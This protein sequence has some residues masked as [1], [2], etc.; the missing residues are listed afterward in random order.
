MPPKQKLGKT[1]ITK[2]PKL[3]TKQAQSSKSNKTII[4][5]EIPDIIG[6]GNYSS[7]NSQ[8]I[9]SATDI[10][11]ITAD[12]LHYIR[13]SKRILQYELKRKR[14]N[15]MT[16]MKKVHR[17]GDEIALPTSTTSDCRLILQDSITTDDLQQGCISLFEQTNS[18]VKLTPIEVS[19]AV[20]FLEYATILIKNRESPHQHLLEKIFPEEEQCQTKL[21]Y[22]LIKLVCHPSDKLR[23]SIV[24]ELKKNM[25]EELASSLGLATT[26]E[27]LYHLLFGERIWMDELC[28]VETFENILVRMGEG[29]QCSDFGLQAFLCFLS[30]RP[31]TV[32]LGICSD[33]AYSIKKENRVV[34]SSRF[35]SKS[36]CALVTPNHQNDAA[37]ILYHFHLF[38]NLID[39]EA[40]VKFVWSGWFSSLFHTL[41]TSKLP[42]IC[43][44]VPLHKQLVNLMISYLI[45]IRNVQNKSELCFLYLLFLQQTKDYIVYLSLHPFSLAHDG[46]DTTIIDF[47]ECLLSYAERIVV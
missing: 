26:G 7:L 31:W 25:T 14:M 41:T 19:Y 30:R 37:V 35:T 2:P 45:T 10:I 44:F 27:G 32:K 28:W 21:T 12:D 20:Y 17:K 15:V 34:S 33:G 18:G 4:L 9:P 38:K 23:A 22:A 40:L 11:T 29:R 1:R 43:D 13:V 3:R 47:F 39:D 8:S 5:A 46:S 6:N 42:F 16:M 36:I 24:D